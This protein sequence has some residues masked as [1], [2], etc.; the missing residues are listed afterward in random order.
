MTE[1]PRSTAEQKPKGGADSLGKELHRHPDSS[2]HETLDEPRVD[3][4]VSDEAHQPDDH[5][6]RSQHHLLPELLKCS[7]NSL[8][9]RAVKIRFSA[10][11]WSSAAGPM[12]TERSRRRKLVC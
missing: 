6:W 12:R 9:V 5:E 7:G 1:S 4:Q 10:A 11:L 2:V 3:V 8:M